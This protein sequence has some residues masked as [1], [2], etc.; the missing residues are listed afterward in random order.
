MKTSMMMSLILFLMISTC[1]S[2][3]RISSW[4]SEKI[5]SVQVESRTT[6]NEIMILLLDERDDIEKVM[7]YL[8]KVDFRDLNGQNVDPLDWQ[9]RITFNGLR[10][11]VYLFENYAFIGKTTFLI[12]TKV[13]K[14]FNNLLKEL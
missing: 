3:N 7:S 12:D 13:V 4:D 11:Q 5:R 8:R 14:E 6:G 2:Q 9:Y 10:D 1:Y